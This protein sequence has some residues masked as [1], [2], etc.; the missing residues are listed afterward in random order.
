MMVMVVVVVRWELVVMGVVGVVVVV[1][2]VPS[3]VVVV[4]CVRV[5]P[6]LVPV[7][8]AAHGL[9]HALVGEQL[10]VGVAA[11]QAEGDRAVVQLD[12]G[13]LLEHD[14]E[15]RH[16]DLVEHGVLG[17]VPDLL[18]VLEL[19]EVAPGIG[20]PHHLPKKERHGCSATVGG[21]RAGDLPGA[22]GRTAY[23][24]RAMRGLGTRQTD[25]FSYQRHKGV[26]LPPTV[27]PRSTD[28]GT[29]WRSS[30]PCPSPPPF[31][32]TCLTSTEQYPNLI[33]ASRDR[34]GW[35]G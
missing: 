33:S 35:G 5:V 21:R 9:A 23:G 6:R 12:G 8:G 28:G 27:E 11:V 14:V 29:F 19:P 15:G 10:P 18:L 2:V 1:V 31:C 7:R 25:C 22:G 16:V 17:R 32:R 26:G 20:G 4:G 34:G 24:S 13:P 3:V 30:G